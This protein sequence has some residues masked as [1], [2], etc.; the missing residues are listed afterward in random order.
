MPNKFT[1]TAIDST[2]PNK[3]KKTEQL[4][5]KQKI[6]TSKILSMLKFNSQHE[7]INKHAVSTKI[8]SQYDRF[9]QIKI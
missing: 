3:V 8:D 1:V 6:M 7:N 5:I 4:F 2:F 9:R